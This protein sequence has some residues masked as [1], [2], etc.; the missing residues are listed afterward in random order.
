MAWW[1]YEF[2]TLNDEEKHLRRESLAYHAAIAHYSLIAPLAALLLLKLVRI[3]VSRVYPGVGGGGGGAYQRVPSSPTIKAHRDGVAAGLLVRW[4]KL[5]WWVSDDV[6]VFG[7]VWGQ[8]DQWIFG[9]V[10][11]LWLL[12]LSVVGTGKG[13]QNRYSP[14]YR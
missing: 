14:F 3:G 9:S 11:M 7:Q 5:V 13:E 4:N 6:L 10:W 8:R 12:T 1:P 2:I